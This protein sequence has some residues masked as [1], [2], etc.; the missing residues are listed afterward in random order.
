MESFRIDGNGAHDYV[1]R[2]EEVGAMS[3]ELVS[4]LLDIDLQT[5]A[6][7]TFSSYTASAFL[8]FGRVFLLRAD[9]IVIGTCVCLRTWERPNEVLLLSMGIRPGWRGRGLGQ[10]FVKGVLD[11]LR[12]R[13]IRSVSLLV[14]ADNRRAMKVY[15]DVGFHTVALVS[16]DDRMVDPMT[17]D[18]MVTMRAT[19][20]EEDPI[21]GIPL[22]Q[23]S[24]VQGSSD[25]PDGIAELSRMEPAAASSSAK[26]SST[27]G[28]TDS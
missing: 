4:V 3:P 9:D 24:A 1:I 15:A 7:S 11:R 20:I 8:K 19:L 22:V 14:E 13:G 6:E 25:G 18:V 16:G 28:P 5:F 26:L 23:S 10:R 27:R 2:V 12:A 17:G 21:I